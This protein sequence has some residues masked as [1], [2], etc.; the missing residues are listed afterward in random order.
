MG[1]YRRSLEVAIGTGPADADITQLLHSWREGRATALSDLVPLAH[2]QLRRVA[3]ACLRRD[4]NIQTL[5]ATGLVHELYV[6]LLRQSNVEFEDRHQFYAFAAW[7]MRCILRDAARERHALKRRSGYVRVALSDDLA[8]ID[9]TGD[10]MLEL[11]RLLNELAVMDARRARLFELKVLL[12]C[13]TQEAAKLLGISKATADR[14]FEFTRDW[15]VERLR[16]GGAAAEEP[17]ETRL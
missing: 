6:L 13:S 14:D 7:L 8:F 10:E 16:S 12:G 1:R 4:R 3:E 11:D 2:P 9:A 15:V 17:R 5:Q